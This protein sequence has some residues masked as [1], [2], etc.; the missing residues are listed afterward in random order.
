MPADL[1]SF[2]LAGALTVSPQ[3]HWT[4][5]GANR[6][7]GDLVQAV[8][9]YADLPKASRERLK[10]KLASHAYD[11]HV[12]ITRQGLSGGRQ[13]YTPQIRDMHFG[14]NKVCRKVKVDKWPARRQVQ[15]LVY[16]D[17]G[18]CLLV[19]SACG[20]LSRVTPAPS[21]DPLDINPAAGPGSS[22]GTPGAALPQG[23]S[24]DLMPSSG[25]PAVLAQA[26][27]A[28]TAPRADS[29][30]TTFPA[31]GPNPWAGGPGLY[32]PYLDPIF[33]VSPVIPEPPSWML[34]LLGMPVV[35]LVALVKRRRGKRPD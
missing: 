5:P 19:P 8:D 7:T 35:A 33:W 25:P 16:C 32:P 22:Q 30:T 6:F 10:A 24:Y 18:H 17:E 14:G 27:P 26:A 3:C 31:H 13:T 28:T 29:G 20:N 11:D 4:H 9:H 34:W 12:V 2:A 15:A 23:L 21:N 1:A